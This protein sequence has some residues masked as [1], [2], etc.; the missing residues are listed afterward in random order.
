[1]AIKAKFKGD[2]SEFHSGI[3]ARDL[4]DE[5][6]DSLSKEDQAVVLA[7]PLYNVTGERDSTEKERAPFVRRV[8]REREAADERAAE[9]TVATEDK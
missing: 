1:M 5:E 4:T 2:G 7:S 3:P 9:P 6:Y 8:E